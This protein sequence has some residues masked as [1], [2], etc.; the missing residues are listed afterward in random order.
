ML[1][2]RAWFEKPDLSLRS[3]KRVSKGEGGRLEA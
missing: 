3:A 1:R 2:S